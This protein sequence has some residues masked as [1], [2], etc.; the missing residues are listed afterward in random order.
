M[1]M[2]PELIAWIGMFL[3]VLARVMLPYLRKMWTGDIKEFKMYYLFT[4]FAGLILSLIITIMIAPEIFIMDG[5]S[6]IQLL[7]ANFLVSF[8]STSLINEVFA[9]QELKESK[10][11]KENIPTK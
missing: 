5:A 7:S 6:F 1:E 4:A 10:S 8:G 11:L 3:G 9:Y 2:T